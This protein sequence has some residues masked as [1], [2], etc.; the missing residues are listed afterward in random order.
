MNNNKK[1]KLK[2]HFWDAKWE[3]FSH[4]LGV[5]FTPVASVTTTVQKISIP[6]SSCP[7]LSWVPESIFSKRFYLNDPQSQQTQPVENWTHYLFSRLAPNQVSPCQGIN[8]TNSHS[9]QNLRNPLDFSHPLPVSTQSPCPTGPASSP[10][11]DSSNHSNSHYHCLNPG[12]SWPAQSL[13]WSLT[14][15]LALTPAPSSSFQP[16]TLGDPS[17]TQ[18]RTCCLFAW[19]PLIAFCCPQ[20]QF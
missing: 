4:P 2:S 13:Y 14:C 5:S 9:G 16:H 3:Y 6:E 1:V 19:K 11:L 10:S 17:E 18:I 20:V 15:L 7:P 12:H 8:S